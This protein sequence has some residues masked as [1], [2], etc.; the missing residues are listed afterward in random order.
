MLINY[1]LTTLGSLLTTTISPVM[2]LSTIFFFIFQASHVHDEK[3]TFFSHFQVIFDCF[4]P[5]KCMLA[6]AFT[7]GNTQQKSIISWKHQLSP[8]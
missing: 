3:G 8:D 7:G 2:F 1:H 6:H 5:C 4:R